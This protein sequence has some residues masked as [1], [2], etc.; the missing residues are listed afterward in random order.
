MVAQQT[1][2]QQAVDH[3]FK[4]LIVGDSAVG[5]SCLLLKFAD[6]KFSNSYVSTIGVD[7]KSRQMVVD[8][9]QVKLQIW[10]TAGQER[11]RTMTSSY[12]RGAHGIIVAYDVTDRE[13]FE[14]VKNWLCDIKRYC[15]RDVCIQ[16]VA[17][18]CDKA[19]RQ[20]STEE[21]SEYAASLGFAFAETSAKRGDG[22]QLCF[23]ALSRAIM[24]QI[25]M[26]PRRSDMA[27]TGVKNFK[28]SEKGNA[29][30][31]LNCFRLFG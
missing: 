22:V 5:K 20:V 9:K 27:R 29:S 26:A 13:S 7:Y 4:V 2:T 23:A 10:D 21:G 15:T 18:K 30:S 17:N 11:F 28:T 1:T 6:D 24:Q 19:E 8:T 25:K 31:W 16:I 12:Y 14:S 3:L